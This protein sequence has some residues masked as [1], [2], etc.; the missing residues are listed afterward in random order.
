MGS[1]GRGWCRSNF[2]GAGHDRR[3]GRCAVEDRRN[4]GQSLIGRPGGDGLEESK[5]WRCREARFVKNS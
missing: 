5:W 4:L 3:D 1:R 2:G